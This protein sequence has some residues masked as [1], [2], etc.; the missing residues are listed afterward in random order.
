[1]KSEKSRQKDNSNLFLK[2]FFKSNLLKEL[3]NSIDSEIKNI[4]F[5]G[6]TGSSL[7]I[8]VSAILNQP[9]RN[10]IFVFRDK[11][12]ALYF[13]NDLE[14]ILDKEILFFPATYRRAY[15]INESDNSNILLRAEV[16][17]KLNINKQ[18]IIITYSEALSEKVISKLELKEKTISLKTNSICDQEELEI[19]LLDEN[20]ECVDFVTDP[21]QYSIRGGIM[22]IFSY[23]NE[24][25]YRIE[26]DDEKIESIRTFNINSQL[27]IESKSKIL[28][29]PNTNCKESIT[30]RTSL[31][32]YLDQKS[33]VWIKDLNYSSG[34]IS[35]FFEKSIEEFHTNN[36]NL[37]LNINE[38]YIG[39]DEFISDLKD[40]KTVEIENPYFTTQKTIIAN[41]EPQ[42]PFNKNI[43][44]LFEKIESNIS[45]N[46]KNI[47]SCSSKEQ[48]D[49]FY[50]LI[51]GK[52]DNSQVKIINLS[53]H[54]GFCDFLNQ[55]EIFTDHQI[56]NRYHK[57]K[58]KT[59][60]ND[61][62]SITLKQLTNLKIGDYV[63]HIDHGIGQF[64][65]LHKISNN[66]VKQEVIKLSYKG[67][68][69]LY[70][71][72]HSL[73]KITK[74]SGQEGRIPKINQLGTPTWSKSKE[75]TKSRI[76]KI[77]FDLIQLYAKRKKNKGFAFSND[78]YM[79][80]E[81][82]ASFM[83]EDTVDQNKATNAIKED[84][85]KEMPMDRLVCGDVGFGK[86]EIA[87]R[88][89]FKA[90]ADNKQV[91]V[92]V[93]TTILA[94]Q[95]FKTFSKRLKKFPCKIDY[96]NRF[97]TK[98]EQNKIIKEID[99]GEIDII[100]GTHRIVGK[101]INF[102]DL[103]LL[104]IDEEQ[105]FGV[106]IKDKLKS[107]K[108]NIDTLTLTA[109]PIPRTLQFSLLGAR[110]LSI[111]NTPPPN[112]QSIET[113]IIGLNEDIISSAINYEISRNGQVFFVHNKIENIEEV[114]SFIGRLCPNAKIKTGH[115][116][117]EGNK[118]EHLMHDFIEGKFDVLVSTTI[119]ENGVD[120]P[121][122]NT[123]II[124]SAQNF[125]LSDLHQMRGR[126]GRSNKKAFCYLI[127]PPTHQISEDS[128]K[129]LNAL[130]QFSNIGS[131]F[132]IAMRDLDIRGAGDLLGADQS[133]FINDI[134]FEMYQ[135]I[136]DE[137]IEELKEEKFKNLFKDEKEIF[138][139]KDCQ[140]DTDIEILIPENYVSNVE[141]RINLYQQLNKINNEN[142]L[143]KFKTEL[144]DRFGNSTKN[145]EELFDAIRLK[146]TGKEIGFEKLVIKNNQLKCYFTSNKSSRYFESENF[147][148]ILNFL[149]TNQQTC[150]LREI[151]D[152]LVLQHHNIISVN[153]AL[154]FLNSIKNYNR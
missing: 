3:Q 43:D 90:V 67:G 127:A 22:D 30:K 52:F 69:I 33:V 2:K 93:P 143:E 119:I 110:D 26:F 149:T 113:K 98:K 5:K 97:R 24:F 58:S 39:G 51:K 48:E 132:K 116:Q 35:D 88:A 28:I 146:W 138:V 60:F 131:G 31:I 29:I 10:H 109:T 126:V 108:T 89:A 82:E 70:I 114:A 104:I 96:L 76:K 66:D 85:E 137:A 78:S 81:L 142:E 8:Y 37:S 123:I 91:A 75:K 63:T 154:N 129:R 65:G 59:K 111:I 38:Y 106:N 14:N 115:G 140:L 18:N 124:N 72:I 152:K 99:S 83:Y 7:S 120:I 102:K 9:K 121:N 54:E 135:R 136:L 147:K 32:K 92:L 74:Y 64:N 125:G 49:R 17:N 130:E 47:I 34:K 19:K 1:M 107:F 36:T 145:I 53:I 20:F 117:M 11:E 21:G 4:Y 105:K 134:G 144:V 23:A 13:N 128:R 45:N 112:R 57:F 50:S 25:P 86:T 46:I 41:C 68:D 94:L 42:S 150:K 122:A 12:E 100:I 77:A 62:Q 87:V 15:Q 148:K 44:L 103:G 139:T 40:F 61:K 95:H 101:D 118:I 56:F 55:V 6:N 16:L 153:N 133:G 80:H 141:E 71:S 73:H 84:M 151:K 79:Q 27:S